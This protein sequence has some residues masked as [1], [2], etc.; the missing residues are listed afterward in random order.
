MVTHNIQYGKRKHVELNFAYGYTL[1]QA[2]E[3]LFDPI[4]YYHETDKK[5]TRRCTI[6]NH[7]PIQAKYYI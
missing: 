5:K 6:I 4:N 3:E 7:I 2:T 1:K